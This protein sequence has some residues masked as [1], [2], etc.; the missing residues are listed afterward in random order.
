MTST[1]LRVVAIAALV[2]LLAR[3]TPPA[4]ADF[5]VAATASAGPGSAS[6]LGQLDLTT[7]GWTAIA[8]LSINVI[9]LTS[10]PGGTLYAGGNDGNLYTLGS[11]STA[12]RFGS[13]SDPYVLSG[14]AYAGSA[15]FV[16]VQAD[17]NPYGADSVKIAP[18]GNSL[19]A[20]SFLGAQFFGFGSSG[21]ALAYGPDGSLYFDALP[22][23]GTLPGLAQLFSL[24]PT[25]GTAIAIGSNL[26]V[27]YD[28]LSL[29]TVGGTLYGIDSVQASG[30]GLIE[31]DAIDTASGKATATGID[32]TGLPDGYTL[33][34]AASVSSVV[35]EPSSLELALVGGMFAGLVRA[36]TRH[37]RA[38]SA[39]HG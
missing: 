30:S 28:P 36:A 37:P 29:V 18:D 19:S 32:V 35:P 39:S 15:G 13:V 31:I 8:T 3:A 12:T 14:L 1:P 11:V 38:R 16:G 10:G 21:G 4:R 33:D 22:L 20:P 17:I 26:G 27:G 6:I 24:D 9:S 23:A 2:V 7:G 5:V 25:T 34:A